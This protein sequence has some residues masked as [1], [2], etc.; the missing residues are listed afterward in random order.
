M[1]LNVILT[2]TTKKHNSTEVPT[3]SGSGVK[4]LSCMLKEGSSIIRPVLIFE[5]ANVGHTYNYVYISDF[6]RYYFV[7]DIVYDGARI[8]YHCSVDVLATYKSTIGNSTQYVLRAAHTYN[9]YVIDQY[10]PTTTRL[11]QYSQ[12]LGQPWSQYNHTGADQFWVVGVVSKGG[13]LYYAFTQAQLDAFMDYIWSEQFVLDMLDILHIDVVLN[14]QLKAAVDPIS[15]LTCCIWFPFSLYANE[16]HTATKFPSVTVEIGGKTTTL[17]GYGV[18]VTALPASGD[19]LAL[20]WEGLPDI[21]PH[22]QSNARGEYLNSPGFTDC[23]L[24]LPPFGV[25]EYNAAELNQYDRLYARVNV[26]CTNG[27]GKLQVF[28]Q[29]ENPSQPNTYLTKTVLTDIQAQ[30]G[31]PLPITQIITPGLS[32]IDMTVRVGGAVASAFM[33]NFGGAAAGAASAIDSFYNSR[34]PRATNIG[35][36]GNVAALYGYA[37][38]EYTWRNVAPDD[39]T[40]NGRPLCEAYQLSTLPGFQL[41]LNPHIHTTGTASEDDQINT[42]LE[43]GYFYE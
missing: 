20:A 16:Q 43:T 4:T 39:N 37:Y 3:M 13:V 17:S 7:D 5:R 34:V 31:V 24:V 12:D 6:S 10:Y 25:F 21:M 38:F 36:R 27:C 9:E 33:G 26:D 30:I 2:N 42:F 1:I 23:R 15:Y 32:V 22:P 29:V 14:P 35:S 11:T 41:I 19:C 40:D 18:N 8:Y 28:G